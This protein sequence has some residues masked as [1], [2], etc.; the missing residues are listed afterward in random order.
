[1]ERSAVWQAEVRARMPSIDAAETEEEREFYLQRLN[2]TL[3][4]M[5]ERRRNMFLLSRIEHKTYGEIAAAYRISTSRVRREI[6]RAVFELRRRT[7]PQDF[8]LWQRIKPVWMY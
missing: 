6:R 4:R 8:S 7:R 2:D 1:M 5:P 3:A